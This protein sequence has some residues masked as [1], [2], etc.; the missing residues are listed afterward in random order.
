ME[1][2]ELKAAWRD[3]D[4]RLERSE[5][6]QSDWRRELALDRTRTA[7]RR[8]LW[9]PGSE[10][11]VSV[12]AAWFAGGYLA[13][14]AGAALASPPG[15]LPALVLWGLGVAG[16]VAG[17]RQIVAVASI[18][19][20]APVLAIQR[21][22][23]EARRLRLRSARA[24]LLAWLPLWPVCAVLAVQWAFGFGSYRQFAPAWLVA[25]VATGVVL[26]LV[27]VWLARRYGQA[28]ARGRVLRRL[29]DSIAGHGLVATTAQLDEL[30][31]FG[32]E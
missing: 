27:L 16:I 25:N 19:Y 24:S 22:L 28:L 3:L 5:S 7:L 2:D 26:D 20:A 12:L 29:S 9:L 17:V 10:L 21:R 30:A 8:W 13:G 32:R 6:V 1:L 31:R 18:D 11:A 14:H 15:A 23:I 4:R